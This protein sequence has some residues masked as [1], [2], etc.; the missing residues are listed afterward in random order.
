MLD[1]WSD[2][3]ESDDIGSA[4]FWFWN[5]G[6]IQQLMVW[7]MVN[8]TVHTFVKTGGAVH[9]TDEDIVNHVTRIGVVIILVFGLVP[10]PGIGN[11]EFVGGTEI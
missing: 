5:E 6:W 10:I 8:S 3:E 4:L 2:E 1:T 11:E 9:G 7:L